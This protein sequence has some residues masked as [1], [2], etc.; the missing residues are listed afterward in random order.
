MRIAAQIFCLAASLAAAPAFAQVGKDGVVLVDTGAG[1]LNERVLA[2]VRQLS[3]KPI[4]FVLNTHAHPDH[5]GGNAV[6][7]K[8]GSRVGARASQMRRSTARGRQV[9]TI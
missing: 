7:A 2:A 8:A 5:I 3:D 4:R 1:T 6:I 9:G